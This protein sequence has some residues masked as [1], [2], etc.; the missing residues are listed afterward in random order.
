MLSNDTVS[1]RYL[2]RRSSKN[3][4]LQFAN[5]DIFKT[6]YSVD[7][8]RGL[9]WSPKR[10]DS[11]NQKR[12]P[13]DARA[14]RDVFDARLPCQGMVKLYKGSIFSSRRHNLPSKVR[15]RNNHT[16][17]MQQYCDIFRQSHSHV[18]CRR[19]MPVTLIW[20]RQSLG[21]SR[22]SGNMAAQLNS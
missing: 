20:P 17:R 13:A 15:L 3:Y 9:T 16:P 8:K 10:K 7:C 19:H 18:S 11:T 21:G 12:L 22:Q 1:L 5:G 6:N 4:D 2:P 14:S